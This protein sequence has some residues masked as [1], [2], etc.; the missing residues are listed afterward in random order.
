MLISLA[1]TFD[2]WKWKTIILILFSISIKWIYFFIIHSLYSNNSPHLFNHFVG[3]D[4]FYMEFCENFYSKGV[5][6]IKTGVAFDYTFRMPAFN[7]LYYPLRIFFSK[8]L[9]MD[10]IIIIQTTL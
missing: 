5:Y 6:F 3:D 10:G 7:F 2:N 4:R 8:E 1:K 9:T